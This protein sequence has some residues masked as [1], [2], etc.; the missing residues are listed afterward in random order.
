M[1]ISDLWLNYRPETFLWWCAQ[2]LKVASR[3]NEKFS[4]KFQGHTTSLTW[5]IKKWFENNNPMTIYL[6]NVNN[7]NT[8]RKCEVCS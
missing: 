2:K 8:R 4:G 7:K 3:I 1:T 5:D 6:F